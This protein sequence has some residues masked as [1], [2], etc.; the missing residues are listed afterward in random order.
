AVCSGFV[1]RSGR[2]GFPQLNNV[3]IRRNLLD[4]IPLQS[5]VS[6]QYSIYIISNQT[7]MI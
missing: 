3:F 5:R 6:I 7:K 4:G 1:E 2:D